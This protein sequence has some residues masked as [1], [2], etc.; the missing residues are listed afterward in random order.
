MEHDRTIQNCFKCIGRICFAH[1]SACLFHLCILV[2]A[3]TL[4][5]K[6]KKS[7]SIIAWAILQCRSKSTLISST[8]HISFSPDAK[9]TT[10][11]DGETDVR[12]D[13]IDTCFAALRDS[14]V[15]YH[16][17]SFFFSSFI[18]CPRNTSRGTSSDSPIG[19][20]PRVH[21]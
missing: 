2:V 5:G 8:M 20:A 13:A 18:L 17:K 9:P 15:I 1:G 10:L 4:P 7:C 16:A 3:F 14:S 11:T 19:S 21:S 6:L 12:K